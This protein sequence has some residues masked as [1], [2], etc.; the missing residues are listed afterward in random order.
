MAAGVGISGQS[1][2]GGET[3]AFSV[4][5]ETVTVRDDWSLL[6]VVP[7]NSVRVLLQRSGQADCV[8]ATSGM[9][10][11]YS[12]S[13]DNELIEGTLGSV[14]GLLGVGAVTND[15]RAA[16]R[17]QPPGAGGQSGNSAEGDMSGMKSFD[18][19]HLLN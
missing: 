7:P 16:S 9:G 12:F 4:F 5:G 17:A 8:V 1:E 14:S 10:R 15:A 18:M 13:A 2:E 3:D 6:V 19:R 11:S